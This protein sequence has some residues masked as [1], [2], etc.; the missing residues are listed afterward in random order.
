V[1]IRQ[2]PSLPPSEG[3]TTLHFDGV[4]VDRVGTTAGALA[5]D[6]NLDA[7]FTVSLAIG[8]GVTRTI[9]HIDLTGPSTRSTRAG[10]APLGV[11]QDAGSALLNASNNT[12]NFP[13]TS[14]TTLTLFAAD[15]GFIVE[16]ATYTVKAVFTDG[17]QFVG[18]YYIVPRE[19]RTYVAH[20]ADV[21]ADPAS[22][23]AGTTAGTTTIT[24]A[25]VRDK[26]GNL[27]PD[28][29]KIALSA[30]DMAAKNGLGS[31][32]RSAGGTIE[33]GTPAANNASFRVFTINN[34][35]VTATY[36]SSPVTPASLTGATAVVQVLAADADDN[37]LGVEAISSIDI[38]IR[39]ASDRA[40]VHPYPAALYADRTD[41][42][43]Q[44]VVDVRDAAGNPVP[45]GT[46]VLLTATANGSQTT[47]CFIGSAG[48]TILGGEASPTG[49]YRAFT[50]ANGRVTA[51]YSSNTLVSNVGEVKFATIQVLA[52]DANGNRAS[53]VALGTGHVALAGAGTSEVAVS[54]QTVPYVF[55][56]P[57]V[58]Q[59][60]VHHAHDARSRLVPDGANLLVSATANAS[61][62]HCCFIGSAGGTIAG[63]TASPTS[64]F[65]RYFP[66]F[67]N[68]FRATWT[69]E[70]VTPVLSG[71][72]RT[73]VVQV[74]AGD[75]AGNRID[76]RALGTANIQVLGPLNA[77][78]SAAEANLFGDGNL[79]TTNVR[80][81]HI[82]DT[83]GNPLP[84]GSKVVVTAASNA[85]WT[86]CCFISSAGGQILNGD[87]S[88]TANFKVFTIANGGI[89][90]TYGNQGIVSNPGQ[91]HTANVVLAQA[92]ANGENLDRLALGIVPVKTVGTTTAQLTASPNAIFAD[93][94]DL[95]TTVTISNVKDS[96]GRAVPDGTLIGVTALSNVTWTS[97]CF[98][99]SA[100]G[101]IIGDRDTGN[102][103]WFKVFPIVNG[104][105]VVEYSAQGVSV[106]PSEGEKTATVSVVSVNAQGNYV[107]RLT[108]GTVQ[109][110]LLAPASG[111]INVEPG[112]LTAFAPVTTSQ[113]VVRELKTSTGDL[114]PDG[115][116][117]GI[118][119]VNNASLTP[120]GCCFNASAGGAIGAAG[121]TEGDGTT[122][123]NNSNFKIFTIAGGEV[124]AV[125]DGLG[126]TAGVDEVKTANVQ[127][128]AADRSGAILTNR[129]IATAPI[130]I[131]GT[132]S[133]TVSAPA[134][135][136]IP[137]TATITYTNIRDA[138]GNIVPDGTPVAVSA[139]NNASLGSCCFNASAGGTI[140][141]GTA[142]PSG[143][144][145]KWF[146]VQNGSVTVEYSTQGVTT[147]PST[148]RIQMVVAR[149]DGSIYNNRSLNGGVAAINL[150]F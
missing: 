85:T 9:S 45:D 144:I 101:A 97:C 36:S 52:A 139:A 95:R 82:L 136:K 92:G 93:G 61:W 65:Y 17:S 50:V 59:V 25:N 63:G 41:R 140:V 30:A 102:S 22:V 33:G 84:E 126:I 26:E 120:S 43:A 147:A 69:Q 54:P 121:T 76:M 18:T 118:S 68:F 31:P 6:G 105:V 133:A 130:R 137:G 11:A 12:I 150:S 134:T 28:G 73:S 23:I 42:R 96:L 83:Q 106:S 119:A 104:Q 49:S 116:K 24:I 125:Y 113:V 55:P 62:N 90:V 21:A 39:A 1:N 8:D 88:P 98:V 112:N 132:S 7:V 141:N 56:N 3:S 37:V 81:E 99:S 148:A 75:P 67:H 145:W 72:E 110:R 14:G 10:F 20:S 127:V 16:G 115:S 15:A 86:S 124:H 80:F 71:Q 131:N 34:G 123:T 128:V 48:G 108:L 129:S 40:I 5:P 146:T 109:I 66:L 53:M 51:E 117:I 70:G 100:G 44:I 46:K 19:D 60:D 138:A 47:C 57:P 77:R 74:L 122:A 89:D 29:G 87:P 27:V 32:F 38:N 142:S 13:V 35:S 143:A 91:T 114:L 149:P 2:T 58:V 103:T 79:Q 135:L 94:S 64:P 111:T 4:L 78:G 107:D